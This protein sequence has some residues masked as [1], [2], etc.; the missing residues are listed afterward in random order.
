VHAA[1][2]ILRTIYGDDLTG[3]PVTLEE[4]ATPI[5]QAMNE[6][7]T[8]AKDLLEVYEKVI[9]AIHLLSNPPE[10]AKTLDADALRSLL[11]ERLDMIRSVTQRTI[12]MT[13]MV[14]SEGGTSA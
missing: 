1:E 8:G 7:L 2:E 6:T 5:Q 4:V 9:E 14:K 10:N 11:G 3:C 12:D 13:K